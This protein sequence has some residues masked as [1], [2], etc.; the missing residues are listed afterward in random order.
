M[1]QTNWVVIIVAALGSAGLGGVITSAIN[2]IV[3]ARK[4]IAG[5]EDDRRND[6]IQQR[7]F[8]IQQIKSAELA[9]DTAE[10]YADNE[11][12]IRIKWQEVAVRLRLQLLNA[13]IEPKWDLPTESIKLR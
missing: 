4:G 2:G 8:A 12:I 10:A 9:A 1:D 7:D 6:V 3:M 11:R 5:R 13:G